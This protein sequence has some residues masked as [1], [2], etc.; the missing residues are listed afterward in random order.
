MLL[1]QET[2]TVDL[3]CPFL[4][5]GQSSAFWQQG[6]GVYTHLQSP[7]RL[8]EQPNLQA[9]REMCQERNSQSSGMHWKGQMGDPGKAR[10]RTWSYG[11]TRKT[12]RRR[13]K[14]EVVKGTCQHQVNE[15]VTWQLACLS[16]WRGLSVR[17]ISSWHQSGTAQS[18][19]PG[20]VLPAQDGPLRRVL[21]QLSSSSLPCQSFPAG[22]FVPLREGTRAGSQPTSPAARG[23]NN[24]PV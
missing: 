11:W 21:G 8:R 7:S 18:I 10:R 19:H 6:G 4:Q 15:A 17:S 3:S 13:R 2:K 1:Q 9:G 20:P 23:T 12:W 24:N 16:Q 22:S 5:E 14:R